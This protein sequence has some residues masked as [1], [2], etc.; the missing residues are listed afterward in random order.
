MPPSPFH[1]EYLGWDRPVLP[2][3]AERLLR[4]GGQAGG[5]EGELDLS[6]HLV[7]V[8]GSR[9]GRRLQELLL[10]GAEALGLP[11]R[12]PEVVTAGAL[13]ERLHRPER[14]APPP[15]AARLAWAGSLKTLPEAHLHLLS[16]RPPRG[17]DL[18]QWLALGRLVEG[19]HRE[20][21]AEGI[22]FREVVGVFARSPLFDDGPRW[23]ALEEARRGAM[24]RLESR[25]WMDR[26]EARKGALG[27]REVRAPGPVW[28]VATPE[29]PGVVREMLAGL[30]GPV[31]A[32]IH[33]PPEEAAG[34][35]PDGTLRPGAWQR[36]ELPLDRARIFVEGGPA[37][38][39][40]RL[41]RELAALAG[42]WS[43]E[44][45]VVGVADPDLVPF[46]ARVLEERGVPLRDPA[47]RPLPRTG[48]W[49]LLQSL[50]RF[51]EE[52]DGAALAEL[53]R[54]P[55]LEEWL[56]EGG[57]A[58]GEGIRALDLWRQAALPGALGPGALPG[59]PED[60]GRRLA[61]G[62]RDRL[63]LLLREFR[64]S[65]PLPAWS[66]PLV[67][68]LREVYGD[69]LLREDRPEERE[70]TVFL[71]ALR[72]VLGDLEALDAADPS[73]PRV[74]GAT[75]L[76]ILLGELEGEVVPP[77]EGDAAVEALGWLELHP[78]DAP[79]LL[80]TGVNDP[81]LP[82]SVV[83]HPFLPDG[84]R[85]AL[86][87]PDNRTR[88]ARDAYRLHAILRSRERTVLLSGRR[89][90]A[91][92]PLRPSPLLLQGSAGVVAQRILSFL[93]EGEE[94]GAG[95]GGD[96]PHGEWPSSGASEA[97]A[98]APSPAA[99]PGTSLPPEPV[100]APPELPLR[101]RV[102]AFR[103]L[104]ADPYL[105]LLTQRIG[106][107][108]PPH[109]PDAWVDDDLR[110]MEAMGFGSLAHRVVEK[111]GRE[112]RQERSAGRMAAGLEEAL[113][114]EVRLRFGARPLPAVQI[115]LAQLQARFQALARVEAAHRAAGWEVVAVEVGAPPEGVPFPVDAGEVRLTGRVDRVD[116]HPEEGWLI[117]DYKTS[118][119]ARTPDQTHRRGRG[120]DR[121]W[122]DL[123]LPLYRRVAPALV[124]RD[125][126][127]L[128]ETPS[129]GD[130]LRLGYY[131]LPRTLESV[132]IALAEWSPEELE[133]ADERAREA[134]RPLLRGEPV[135]FD[136]GRLARI[137]DDLA[138]LL[139]VGILAPPGDEGD[140]GDR[141]DPDD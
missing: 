14:P 72:R 96:G 11:L 60:R 48:P 105:W 38:Q 63:G 30:E 54:H 97:T 76:R 82:S 52:E 18:L 112:L 23:E 78:D 77:A 35:H 47:G 135:A 41:V 56:R 88:R 98:P 13:P 81:F 103:T 68:L 57:I 110:E 20:L 93:G 127:P 124:G 134:L 61:Q 109:A 120:R 99:A 22:A 45:V 114:E 25:G 16:A 12:P 95:G 26:D 75:A 4:A 39:A 1:P 33:A 138:P 5:A 106:G 122:V 24:E 133:E 51:L 37:D 89:S 10:E 2:A 115:Q 27:R 8:P 131:N 139:G 28:L 53:A 31:R 58:P 113:R 140:G 104:L 119:R 19:L 90:A 141:E 32:L 59:L 44:E 136:P 116:R 15:L 117:L 34:F 102:T 42:R 40:A 85:S 64:E 126:S 62:V 118:E 129:A 79:V 100:L 123:Q 70:L 128:A 9:A 121:A 43:P 130:P 3:A 125:G 101:I 74:D 49:L 67:L 69:R 6:G 111:L 55:A 83:G 108:Y 84:L 132:G 73:P 36:R 94:A 29:L 80:L 46:L 50:A 21:A 65:R 91:G 71:T 92:D 87:L 7:V 86:G 107:R 137:S 17:D 66:G